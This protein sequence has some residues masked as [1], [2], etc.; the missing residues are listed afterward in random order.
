MKNPDI[1][2]P[3]TFLNEGRLTITFLA[4]RLAIIRLRLATSDFKFIIF[5]DLLLSLDMSYRDIIIDMICKMFSDYQL[6]FMT[7]DK[8]FFNLL[9]SKVDS[10]NW[11]FMELKPNNGCL[12]VEESKSP[13][14]RAREFLANADYD[15]C[16]LYIRKSLEDVVSKLM[17]E[18]DSCCDIY[19]PLE[20]R[21]KGL[22]KIIEQDSLIQISKK[23]I[24]SD[25]NLS[26]SDIE[27]LK[28]DFENDTSL[29]DN[30]KKQ[31]KKFQT[32]VYNYLSE[33]Y[34]TQDHASLIL[35]DMDSIKNRLH[36]SAH[37]TP[38]TPLY[39]KELEEAI[40]VVEKLF[41]IARN[42]SI[43]SV[44]KQYKHTKDSNNST[45]KQEIPIQKALL[46]LDKALEANL[47]DNN[48]ITEILQLIVDNKL[49]INARQ[50]EDSFDYLYN[51]RIAELA[52]ADVNSFITEL[53][54]HKTWNDPEKI[55][56]GE[57]VAQLLNSNIRIND[58][59]KTKLEKIDCYPVW[60]DYQFGGS[61]E[62]YPK[63]S[64]STETEHVPMQVTN[65][66][67]PF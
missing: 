28:T 15:L 62:Y 7:H 17:N 33:L 42:K 63:T 22:K 59:V 10:A 41:S 55:H 51:K 35:A 26:L 60:E 40:K 6:I 39:R 47:D 27:L 13:I 43:V 3:H 58:R 23:I 25:L 44:K 31:L 34:K 2:K 66:D 57:F 38:N 9:K 56:I 29:P 54:K 32:A 5:D 20:D 1:P 4:I 8:G 61:W 24:D 67:V 30:K 52:N 46:A 48:G 64:N 14:E 18:P 21:L 11:K 49:S 16:G 45:S 36:S 53:I 19:I 12:F 50:L 37:H 65:D